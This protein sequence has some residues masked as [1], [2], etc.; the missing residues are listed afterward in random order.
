MPKA[1]PP[2]KKVRP[3]SSR[4][5]APRWNDAA[6][7]NQ[8]YEQKKTAIILAA[9]REFRARGFHNTSLDDVAA[10][11]NVTKPAL[12]YYVKGKSELLFEIMNLSLDMGDAALE[13]G[14]QGGNGLERLQRTIG[15]YIELNIGDSASLL[16]LTNLQDVAPEHIQI[17]KRRRRRFDT[18]LRQFVVEGIADGSLAPN[19]PKIVVFWAMGAANA[20]PGWYTAGGTHSGTQIAAKFAEL[21]AS[22]VSAPK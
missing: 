6:A 13:F 12:Y 18:V 19:D 1:R 11:L 17:I 22:G 8:A 21:L 4:P 7:A 15:K 9:G 3:S 14:R 2:T 10:A 5:S 16:A 20:V